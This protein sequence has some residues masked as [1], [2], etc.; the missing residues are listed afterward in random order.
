M[1][2]AE[3]RDGLAL[4]GP[5]APVEYDAD[6]NPLPLNPL[7]AGDGLAGETGRS[8]F[9]GV[10]GGTAKPRK[11]KLR[12]VKYRA[13]DIGIHLEVG[14]GNSVVSVVIVDY[15][16][17]TRKHTLLL[18][19]GSEEAYRLSGRGSRGVLHLPSTRRRRGQTLQWQVVRGAL[20]ERLV[21]GGA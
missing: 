20:G 19:S 9:F 11:A 12:H 8:M 14:E 10:L 2:C 15:D 13:S 6:G 16:P 18:Q 1:G 17:A 7:Q 4:G 3:S 5:A 21:R